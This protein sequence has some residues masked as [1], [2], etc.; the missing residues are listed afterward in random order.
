MTTLK[1]NREGQTPQVRAPRPPRARTLLL[2]CG[3]VSTLLYLF[4]DLLG[5]L[6]Y[7]GYSFGSQ[8]ISE[9]VAI[10]APTRGVV[11]TLFVAYDVLAVAFGV[12][13]LWAAGRSRALRLTGILLVGY[14]LVGW[15]G[16]GSAPIHQRGAG[17]L[18]DDLPHV[19]VAAVI[20]GLLVLTIA[21][22]AVALGWRFRLYSLATVAAMAAFSAVTFP[23]APRIAAGEPTPWIGVYER[24][25]VY[26]PLLWLAVLAVA[27]LRRGAAVPGG[28]APR[29][30]GF[31]HIAPGHDRGGRAYP[32]PA[33]V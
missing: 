20:V 5:G 9:L 27:L 15:A 31:V 10:G 30:H 33:G 28:A 16:F 8:T 19:I 22:G 7:P 6:R 3:I 21:A 4:A 1:I 2:A 12:G 13:V 17:T 23:Y 32:R 25:V 26:A 18:E 24:I 14:A 11:S 29:T